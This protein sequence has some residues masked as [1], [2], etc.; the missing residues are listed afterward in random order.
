MQRAVAYHDGRT[1]RDRLGRRRSLDG[2]NADVDGLGLA[3]DIARVQ[4]RWVWCAARP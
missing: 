1:R 4:A 3:L 2:G